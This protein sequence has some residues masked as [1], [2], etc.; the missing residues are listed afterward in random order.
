ILY[1]LCLPNND[2]TTLVT[3]K[4]KIEK[5]NVQIDNNNKSN[6]KNPV[7]SLSKIVQQEYVQSNYACL[8]YDVNSFY[9]SLPKT[10]NT[11]AGDLFTALTPSQPPEGCI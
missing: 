1:L 4:N 2:K 7:T 10:S 6:Q 5:N 9:I 3:A 8:I 11:K